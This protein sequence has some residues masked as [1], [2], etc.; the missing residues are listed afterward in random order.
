MSD[1]EN[2]F[3]PSPADK[4]KYVTRHLFAQLYSLF[5]HFCS[6]LIV[7]Q[8][9]SK[10]DDENGT[11]KKSRAAGPLEIVRARN[12]VTQFSATRPLP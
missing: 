12:S 1:K 5:F 11:K 10:S 2:E 4:P 3:R 6:G 7:E 8:D 9:D